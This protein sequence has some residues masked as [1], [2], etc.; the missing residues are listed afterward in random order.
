MKGGWGDLLKQKFKK[1]KPVGIN[2]S[3]GIEG[4]SVVHKTK[5]NEN[6]VNPGKPFNGRMYCSS[7]DQCNMR[8]FFIIETF[9]DLERSNKIPINVYGKFFHSHNT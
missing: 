5:Q 4:N 2:C 6:M 9:D 3:L 1:N 7:K 8:W